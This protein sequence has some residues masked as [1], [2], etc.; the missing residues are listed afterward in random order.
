V[1]LFEF[2]P[3]ERRAL[4]GIA[5]RARN[6]AAVPSDAWCRWTGAPCAAEFREYFYNCIAYAAIDF[7]PTAAERLRTPGETKAALRKIARLAGSM[8]RDAAA[9]LAELGKADVRTRAALSART[10]EDVR[11]PETGR[12]VQALVGGPEA[13]QATVEWL[14]Q[15]HTAE[16]AARAQRAV[17]RYPKRRGKFDDVQRRRAGAWV[18]GFCELF[19]VPYARTSSSDVIAEGDAVRLFRIITGVRARRVEHFLP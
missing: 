19:G 7:R 17:Q 6:L 11:D 10:L 8:R 16:L 18:R 12:A 5:A 4:E 13:V 14:A 15:P 2:T 3:K 1:T 9:L